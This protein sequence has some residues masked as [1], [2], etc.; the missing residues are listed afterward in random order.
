MSSAKNFLKNFF[1][2]TSIRETHQIWPCTWWPQLP[3]KKCNIVFQTNSDLND[4]LSGHKQ[5]QVENSISVCEESDDECYSDD[6][7]F[8]TDTCNYCGLICNLFEELD[9]HT[10][11]LLHYESSKVCFHNEF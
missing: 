5:N 7:N 2:P 8:Y 3:C 6:N 10:S 1:I 4:H 9:H 11:N